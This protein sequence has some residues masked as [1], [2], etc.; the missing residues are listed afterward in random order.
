MVHLRLFFLL[1]IVSS[2]RWFVSLIYTVTPILY[3]STLLHSP[4]KMASFKRIHGAAAADCRGP[5]GRVF[6]TI[7]LERKY[8]RRIGIKNQ[9]LFF[10]P[11]LIPCWRCSSLDMASDVE[12][13]D[14][15]GLPFIQMQ[16]RSNLLHVHIILGL[17]CIKEYSRLYNRMRIEWNKIGK[18]KEKAMDIIN[19]LWR[20]KEHF[21]TVCWRCIKIRKYPIILKFYISISHFGRNRR[22][23]S[24]IRS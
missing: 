8:K 4:Y 13:F 1:F 3:L 9:F 14:R 12:G 22:E 16:K 19:W 24:E 21:G 18:K 5:A 11:Y 2:W 6:Y 20:T 15:D 7:Y 17:Q 23:E 10:K